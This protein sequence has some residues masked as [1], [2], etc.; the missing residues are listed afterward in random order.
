MASPM[1]VDVSELRG[2]AYRCLDGCA[3]CCLCQPELSMDE[4]AVFRKF[5]LFLDAGWRIARLSGFSGRYQ[6]TYNGESEDP[7]EFRLLYYEENEEWLNTVFKRFNLPGGWGGGTIAFA[8]EAVIDM[9]GFFLKAG[10]RVS[11]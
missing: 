7:V 5:G 1:D 10:L 8:H 2:K 9:S 6:E 3:M 4:L 11:F